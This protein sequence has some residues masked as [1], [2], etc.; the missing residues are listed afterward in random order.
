[1][2]KKRI[3]GTEFAADLQRFANFPNKK[4]VGKYA[5]GQLY[6]VNDMDN[7]YL[8]GFALC[9]YKNVP[10][11]YLTIADFF[12]EDCNLEWFEEVGDIVVWQIKD[13]FVRTRYI[14]KA[15]DG[16]IFHEENIDGEDVIVFYIEGDY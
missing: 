3:T 10:A 7:D 5:D 6:Y 14:A 1:M 8:P 4:V 15:E 12:G 13:G 9:R 16:T 2:R 11:D